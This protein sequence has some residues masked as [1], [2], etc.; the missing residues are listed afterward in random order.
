[1]NSKLV[2]LVNETFVETALKEAIAYIDIVLLQI[3]NTIATTSLSI[4]SLFAK[5][6]I[7]DD[8]WFIFIKNKSR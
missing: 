2:K 4:D 5:A 6:E 1:M 8:F 3:I 7:R